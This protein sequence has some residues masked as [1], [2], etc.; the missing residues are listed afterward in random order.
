MLD[1][2]PFIHDFLRLR[3]IL[4]CLC[5][6]TLVSMVCWYQHLNT[7]LQQKRTVSLAA[8]LRL[9]KT[10][11]RPR[12]GC[13]LL[14]VGRVRC[15]CANTLISP[16]YDTTARPHLAFCNLVPAATPFFPCPYAVD[17][18]TYIIEARSAFW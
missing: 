7:N 6:A 9:S 10:I 15:R 14:D 3:A 17:T 13:A 8:L 11:G 18:L 16:F 5:R 2:Q 12:L 4:R 1:S